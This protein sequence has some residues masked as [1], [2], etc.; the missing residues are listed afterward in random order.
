MFLCSV[1]DSNT[2]MVWNLNLNL[3]SRNIAFFG[4]LCEML[5]IY[6]Y[7]MIKYLHVELKW[8]NQGLFCYYFSIVALA[9]GACRC[10]FSS[11]RTKKK[12]ERSCLLLQLMHCLLWRL[13]IFLAGW[14]EDLVLVPEEKDMKD[15]HYSYTLL[16]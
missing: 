15:L 12:E 14:P 8:V 3:Q 1:S 16:Y 11:G 10:I 9:C 5:Q 13:W 2:S 7:Y 4:F 6:V